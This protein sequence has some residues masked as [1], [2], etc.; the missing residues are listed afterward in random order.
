MF[1]FF[2]FSP[3]VYFTLLETL[4]SDSFMALYIFMIL[5][6]KE[7]YVISLHF[8]GLCQELIFSVLGSFLWVVSLGLGEQLKPIGLAP[9]VWL[10]R[11][12]VWSFLNP[13]ATPATLIYIQQKIHTYT[14]KQL[15]V[16]PLFTLIRA[17]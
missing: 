3:F 1:L 10:P 11:L 17:K 5:L 12:C 8:I 2:H 9:M 14:T 15:C 4:L 7:Y 16:L 6:S 13:S